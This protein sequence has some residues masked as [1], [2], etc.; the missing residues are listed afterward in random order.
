[1][2]RRGGIHLDFFFGRLPV[3]RRIAAHNLDSHFHTVLFVDALEHLAILSGPEFSGDLVTPCG[4]LRL[5][6]D[7]LSN[8]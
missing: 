6:I 5:F 7:A 8:S 3:D 2:G 4:E 1:M